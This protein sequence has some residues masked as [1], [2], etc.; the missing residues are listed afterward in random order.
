MHICFFFVLTHYLCLENV[1]AGHSKMED[2]HQQTAAPED[3]SE[4][5]PS[6]GHVKSLMT[7]D[8]MK[9][10]YGM[11]SP[12]CFIHLGSYICYKSEWFFLNVADNSFVS[13]SSITVDDYLVKC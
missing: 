2:L 12:V 11:D 13:L 8:N 6:S 5:I 9:A 10:S 7:E 1:D 3:S 4:S